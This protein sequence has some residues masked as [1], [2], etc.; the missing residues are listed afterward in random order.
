MVKHLRVLIIFLLWFLLSLNLTLIPTHLKAEVNQEKLS[1]KIS[2]VAEVN[3]QLLLLPGT[4]FQKDSLI[5]SANSHWMNLAREQAERGQWNE[6]IETWQ[7]AVK[8]FESEG[9][10]LN[11]SIALIN[12]SLSYQK[13]GE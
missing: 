13:L 4:N 7:K 5:A 3:S 10:Y 9:D 12:L 6:V 2:D 1:A 11:Q 8:T